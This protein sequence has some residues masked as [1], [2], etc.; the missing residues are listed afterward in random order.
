MFILG[1]NLSPD[2]VARPLYGRDLAVPGTLLPI[3]G[4]ILGQEIVAHEHD[5]AAS[6]DA[7]KKVLAGHFRREDEILVDLL[8]Q[9]GG[10]VL[11]EL[12]VE[13]ESGEDLVG[14]KV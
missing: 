11:G 3:G 1:G 7:N 10:F 8:D 5:L 12:T 4:E 14:A 6:V 9:L 2:S 13:H